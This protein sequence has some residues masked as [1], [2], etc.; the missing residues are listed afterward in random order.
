MSETTALFHQK[1]ADGLNP[2]QR[3]ANDLIGAVR[4]TAAELFDIPYRAPESSQAYDLVRE[5]YWVTRNWSLTLIP[6]LGG[7]LSHFMPVGS[8]QSKIE[9][10]LMEQIEA[11]VIRN[12]E[13]LR[14]ETFQSLNRTFDRFGDELQHRMADTITATQ[15]AIIA[16]IALRDQK[17]ESAAPEISRLEATVTKLELIRSQFGTLKSEPDMNVLAIYEK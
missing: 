5:P 14:W 8:Q 1:I 13:N 16:A 2:H 4:Q 17:S 15:G 6:V 12:V 3:R 10:K 7:V 9:K 11:L